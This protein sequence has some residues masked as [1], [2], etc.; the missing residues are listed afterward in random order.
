MTIR[1]DPN[2]PAGARR[3]HRFYVAAGTGAAACCVCGDKLTAQ[4]MNLY[5]HCP[6][7]VFTDRDLDDGTPTKSHKKAVDWSARIK[8]RKKRA[9]NERRMRARAMSVFESMRKPP[10]A[11]R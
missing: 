11:T 7:R 6:G 5:A 2:A 3:P 10:E 4:N 9:T 1:V 8:L